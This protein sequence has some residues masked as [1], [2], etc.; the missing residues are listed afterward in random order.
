MIASHSATVEGP[1]FL[2]AA[3]RRAGVQKA[4]RRCAL[5]NVAASALLT[6]PFR[7]ATLDRVLERIGRDVV[8]S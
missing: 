1:T 7:G 4:C 8:R 3:S 5:G 2:A 6:E